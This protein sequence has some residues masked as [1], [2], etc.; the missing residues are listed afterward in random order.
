MLDL[1]VALPRLAERVARQKPVTILAIGSSS[2]S[3]AG[4]SSER[5]TYPARLAA[6]WPG[7]WP[8]SPVA[9][10]N[11]GVGGEDARQMI[12]RFERDVRPA[13]ADLVLWQL[14]VNA[15]LSMDGVSGQR[16][17]IKEGVAR[18]KAFGL[19]VVLVDLQ[20]APK[21][22]AD[23]DHMVMVRLLKSLARD[24]GVGLFRRFAIMRHWQTSSALAG[25]PLITSDGMHMTDRGYDCWAS[26]L[27]LALARAVSPSLPTT[28]AAVRA[29]SSKR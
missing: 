9:V 23:P 5:T 27:A 8:N 16:A 7:L 3:G 2:T 20:Y 17:V 29:G 15:V 11:R 26:A 14:G 28:E 22:L 18:L 10:I 12:D 1:G 19:D 4:A 25:E 13:D 6:Y 21:V 24:T